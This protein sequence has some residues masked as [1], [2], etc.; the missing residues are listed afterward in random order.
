M[1]VH[2]TGCY[3][4]MYMKTQELGWRETQEIKNIGIEDSQGNT[5]VDQRKVLKIWENCVTDLY[6][7][8]N[9][10]ATV[11]VEPEEEVDTDEKGPYVLQGEVE[12]S[13]K[14]MRIRKATG[15]DEIPGDVLK[16]LGEGGL[17]ILTKL[18]N[19]IYETG[20][21]PK[22]FTEIT[23]IAL[24]TKCNNHRTIGLIAHTA[25]IIA[26]ILRRRIERKIETV[27]GEDRFG[28]RR[29]KG[30]RDA[31][32]MMRITAERT[33]EIDEE[34]CVC[35]ID[36]QKAWNKLMQ[37]LKRTGTDWRERKLISKLYMDQ[38]VKV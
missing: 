38:R 36:W 9:R 34:L 33:L 3:D 22:D 31:I 8:P 35:F 4:L 20:E 1:E 16:L 13:I 28:F 17:K 7:R 14:E 2:R 5:I 15:D 29:E 37:I 23:M 11:E 6:D 24:P 32:G 18:I 19:T 10:P 26:K 27:L 25:K 12:K 21:W 30:T